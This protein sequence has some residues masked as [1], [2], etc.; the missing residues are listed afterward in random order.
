[1]INTRNEDCESDSAH[2]ESTTP[3][4]KKQIILAHVIIELKDQP[5]ELLKALEIFKVIIK[6]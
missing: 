6:S 4:Q 5:W 3:V 1:M 2:I